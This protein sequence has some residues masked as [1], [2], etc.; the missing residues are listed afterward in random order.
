MK[1]IYFLLFMAF[2]LP[3]SAQ[4]VSGPVQDDNSETNTFKLYPNPSNSGGVHITTANNRI[5]DIVV[6][7]VFGAIVLK[8]RITT[9]YLNISKLSPGVYVL[10]VSE[11]QKVMA[12]K[13]VI[14]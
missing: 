14:K 11:D 4:E 9:T 1:I 10:Q 5:K 6:Y 8:D 2:S 3:I 12:R 13:L 7:D